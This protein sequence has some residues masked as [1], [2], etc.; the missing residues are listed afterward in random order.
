MQTLSIDTERGMN[1]P[2][3]RGKYFSLC[4]ANKEVYVPSRFEIEEYCSTSRHAICP[5]YGKEKSR[6]ALAG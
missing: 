5:L 2:C 3:R 4:N 6:Q 1:C